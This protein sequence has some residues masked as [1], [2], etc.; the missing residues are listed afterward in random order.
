MASCT[1]RRFSLLI[2]ATLIQT[3]LTIQIG[4]NFIRHSHSFCWQVVAK[5]GIYQIRLVLFTNSG[6]FAPVLLSYYITDILLD[7]EPEDIYDEVAGTIEKMRKELIEGQK[8]EQIV[9][10]AIHLKQ[11]NKADLQFGD[12][13]LITTRNS[14]YS[15]YV[16]DNSLQCIGISFLGLLQIFPNFPQYPPSDI[17]K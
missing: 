9:D 5:K 15:A 13:V 6:H 17:L 7:N 1:A 4:K 14:V 16:L 12:L 11:V 3:I 8:V 2:A 10:G